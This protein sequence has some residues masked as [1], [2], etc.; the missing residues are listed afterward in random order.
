[1]WFTGART[2]V[3]PARHHTP[4]TAFQICGSCRD[5]HLAGLPD[6]EPYRLESINDFSCAVVVSNKLTLIWDFPSP[7]QSNGRT[8]LSVCIQFGLPFWKVFSHK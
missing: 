5:L 7:S 6:I 3:H 1:M 4:V 2:Q 8:E